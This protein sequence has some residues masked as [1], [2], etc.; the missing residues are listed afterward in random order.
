MIEI[1]IANIDNKNILSFKYNGQI[2]F[3]EMGDDERGVLVTLL[4]EKPIKQLM[5][6]CMMAL[7]DLKAKNALEEAKAKPIRFIGVDYS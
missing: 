4:G 1:S 6:M 7:R 3:G 5:N 2:F